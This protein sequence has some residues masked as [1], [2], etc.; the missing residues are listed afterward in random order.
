MSLVLEQLVEQNGSIDTDE[1]RSEHSQAIDVYAIGTTVLYTP[2]PMFGSGMG[3]SAPLIPP[4]LPDLPIQQY[5]HDLVKIPVA[6]RSSEDDC[7]GLLNPQSFQMGY[8]LPGENSQ[9]H[10]HGPDK[11]SISHG[12]LLDYN[13]NLL[14]ELNGYEA[15]MAALNLDLS[16][17]KKFFKNSGDDQ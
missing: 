7:Y 1:L 15:A 2:P 11:T 10:L 12:H 9:L 8:E 3:Y 13:R 14:G 6:K 16:G 4:K 17:A 5:A